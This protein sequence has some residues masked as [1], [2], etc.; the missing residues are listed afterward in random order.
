MPKLTILLSITGRKKAESAGADIIRRL[1]KLI[2]NM[3]APA[4]TQYA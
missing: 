1:L 3:A 4:Q 2:M